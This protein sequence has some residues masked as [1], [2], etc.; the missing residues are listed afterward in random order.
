VELRALVAFTLLLLAELTEVLN[1]SGD[2]VIV[3]VEVDSAFLVW[4][5]NCVSIAAN[6]E[7]LMVRMLLGGQSRI[8]R[9]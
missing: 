6:L 3:K 5:V 7:Y 1:G 4:K 2:D 9:R 8:V